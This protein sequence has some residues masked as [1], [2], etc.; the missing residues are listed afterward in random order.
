M[1]SLTSVVRILEILAKDLNC[2]KTTSCGRLFDAVAAMSGGC[3]VIGYEAQAAIEFMVAG[4]SAEALPFEFGL[5]PGGDRLIM[6]VAPIFHGVVAALK[7]EEGLALISRRFP[8]PLVLLLT[9]VASRARQATGLNTVALSGGVFQNQV[10][11]PPL[12]AELDRAGFQILTHA[13]LPCGDGCLSLGQA[14]IGR[15]ALLRRILT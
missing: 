11:F 13:L 2:P 6:E 12:L 1:S 4:G 5:R 15:D 9:E 14:V 10:L 3:Q 7:H 8:R